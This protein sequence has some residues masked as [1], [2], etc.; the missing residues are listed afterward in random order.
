MSYHYS[1]TYLAALCMLLVLSL[2]VLL[3]PA[4]A[5]DPKENH[6]NQDHSHP[7]VSEAES[8]T[9]VQ[10]PA[11]HAITIYIDTNWGSRTKRA[12]KKITESHQEYASKGYRLQDVDLYIENGDL[13]G[14]FVTYEPEME[15]AER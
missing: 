4:H 10:A 6:D 9:D 7:Q 12:A 5:I 14:F 8:E 15:V 3:A 13:R 2:S 11:N 1:S